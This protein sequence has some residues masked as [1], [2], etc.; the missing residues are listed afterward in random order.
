MNFRPRVAGRLLEYKLNRI[1]ARTEPW[2]RPLRWGLQELVSL[3]MCNLKRRS[4]SSGNMTSYPFL[5][6]AAA[7]AKYYFRFPICWCRC[8]QKAKIYQQTKFRPDIAIGGRDITTSGFEIQTSAILEFYFLFRS[9]PFCRNR[10]VILHTVAEFRPIRNIRR[11]N[12]TSY[13]FSRWLPSAMLCLLWGNGGPPTKCLSW[14]K[15]RP[16]IARSSD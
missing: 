11:W 16:Q 5:K 1:G 12:M 6:M 3:P 13:R 2:E 10:R 7:N 15:F 9:R 14:S 8:L 4:R